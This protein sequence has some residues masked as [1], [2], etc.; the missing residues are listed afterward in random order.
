MK[1]TITI[2]LDTEI[3]EKLKGEDNY[4]EVINEEMKAHYIYGNDI[5]LQVL[6]KKRSEIKQLLKESRK[7]L[8]IINKKIDKVKEKEKETLEKIKHQAP[9]K[10]L[11]TSQDLYDIERWEKIINYNKTSEKLKSFY[12]KKIQELK[13]GVQNG[14]R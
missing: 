10:K 12:R 2:S 6:V 13:G 8:Q 11:L 3:I 9:K 4:S 7:N 5:S 1:S 14:L